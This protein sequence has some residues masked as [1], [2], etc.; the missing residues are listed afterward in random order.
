M[1]AYIPFGY[2]VDQ[3]RKLHL[4]SCEQEI[5]ANSHGPHVHGQSI[6][7]ELYD[8]GRTISRTAPQ[9][10]PVS[11]A[12]VFVAW[13]HICRN[14]VVPN[15]DLENQEGSVR[16][17]CKRQFEPHCSACAQRILP[18]AANLSLEESFPAASSKFSQGK[19]FSHDEEYT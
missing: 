7:L 2:I 14:T 17:M 8:L 19:K 13:I 10:G 16:R 4:Q 5:Q 11:Q 12:V 15:L 9:V 3:R 6:S 1:Q 18:R